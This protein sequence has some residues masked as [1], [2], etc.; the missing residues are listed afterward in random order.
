MMALHFLVPWYKV[1]HFPWTLAGIAPFL[2]G[3]VLNLSADRALKMRQTT[4]KPFEKSAVLVTTGSY[5]ISRHP[6]YLGF[7]L[8]LLGIAI[9]M[10]S[11]TPFLPVLLFAI[12]MELVFIRVEERMMAAEFDDAWLAYKAN[13]RRWI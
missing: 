13:V 4:V 11:L 12:L 1:I 6:M 3:V 9:F 8:I 5:A 10:G 2:I 7:V